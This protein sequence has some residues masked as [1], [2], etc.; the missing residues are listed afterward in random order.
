M[1]RAAGRPAAV[2]VAGRVE[3][4]VEAPAEGRLAAQP[5]NKRF[6]FNGNVARKSHEISV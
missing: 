6:G 2:L 5:A 1:R 4:R 3:A